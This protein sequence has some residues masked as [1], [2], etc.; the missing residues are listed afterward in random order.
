MPNENK[1][2]NAGDKIPSFELPD[3]NGAVHKAEQYEGK[4][5]IIYF[6]RGTW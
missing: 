6:M 5:L 3:V 1:G 4:P 2:L